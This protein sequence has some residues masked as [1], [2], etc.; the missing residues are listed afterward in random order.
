M[1]ELKFKKVLAFQKFFLFSSQVVELV[2][3]EE[4]GKVGRGW[5]RVPVSPASG[6]S[7]CCINLQP[8]NNYQ[9]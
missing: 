7:T 5:W 9:M 2:E 6:C 1:L 8:P 4:I 3:E